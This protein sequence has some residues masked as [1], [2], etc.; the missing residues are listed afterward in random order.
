LAH[1]NIIFAEILIN[2]KMNITLTLTPEL[3]LEQALEQAGIEDP[4]AVSELTVHGN[5]TGDDLE[6]IRENMDETLIKIDMG[7]ASFE[8]NM[9]PESAFS[10]CSGLRSVIISDSVTHIGEDAFCNCI[11]LQSLIIPD[12]V[13]HIGKMAFDGCGFTSVIIPA[14]VTHIGGGAFDSNTVVSVHPDNPF[15]KSENGKLVEKE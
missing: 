7:G 4:A 8:G 3:R 13:T 10:R 11:G 14:S 2:K 1:G 15:Y 6:Y 12:S 5:V 9:I